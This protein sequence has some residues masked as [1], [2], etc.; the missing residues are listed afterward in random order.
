VASREVKDKELAPNGRSPVKRHK[1]GRGVIRINARTADALDNPDD[2]KTW[3]EEELRRGYRRAA[4]G[5]FKGRPPKVVPMECYHEL[6]RR[7]LK[8]AEVLMQTNLQKAVEQLVALVDSPF[9]DD[10]ARLKAIDMIMNRV[11]GKAPEKVSVAVSV[12]EPKWMQAMKEAT[13]VGEHGVLDVGS[14]EVK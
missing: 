10:N 14:E 4:D 5:T 12:E 9:T 3:D 11:M 13:V 8:D 1:S 2:V 6:Q 7:V